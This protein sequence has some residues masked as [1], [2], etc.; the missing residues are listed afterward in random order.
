MR[1]SQ[2]SRGN[3]VTADTE[4][5]ASLMLIITVTILLLGMPCN[6]ESLGLL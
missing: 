3:V 2:V 5:C 6:L 4:L 1:T